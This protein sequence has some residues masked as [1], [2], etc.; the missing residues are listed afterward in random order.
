[1]RRLLAAGVLPARGPLAGHP[2]SPTDRVPPRRA[3]VQPGGRA[4]TL[5]RHGRCKRRPET[6]HGT[7]D[8]VTRYDRSSLWRVCG[9]RYPRS[10]QKPTRSSS[11][12]GP[13]ATEG[14]VFARLRAAPRVS[15]PRFRRHR[16]R[17]RSSPASGPSGLETP[18]GA[19]SMHRAAPIVGR[20]PP[21]APWF[22]HS[23]VSPTRH[24]SAMCATASMICGVNGLHLSP[25]TATGNSS[26]NAWCSPV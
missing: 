8:R 23:G 15:H 2:G 5:A 21:G 13:R 4:P 22:V 3:R 18:A 17:R 7:R 11:A 19:L 6:D 10:V 26:K 20:S 12:R 24:T 14:R 16:T 1:M 25:R 9:G